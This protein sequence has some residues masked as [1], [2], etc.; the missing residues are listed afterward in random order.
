MSKKSIV[1]AFSNKLLQF[2]KYLE[3]VSGMQEISNLK[4]ALNLAVKTGQSSILSNIL[5]QFMLQTQNYYKEI[6]EHNESFFLTVS[7]SSFLPDNEEEYGEYNPANCVNEVTTFKDIWS[8]KLT[9]DEKDNIWKDMEI[10]MKL[11]ASYYVQQ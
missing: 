2:M 4:T 1:I 7:I 11:G 6:F 10:L 3:E 8:K 5:E 9:S